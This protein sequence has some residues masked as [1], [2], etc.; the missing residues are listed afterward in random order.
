MRVP[1]IRERLRDQRRSALVGRE[2]ELARLLAALDEDGP[3]LTFVLGLGG[4]GKTSLLEAFVTRLEERAIPVRRLDC[5][6]V[7]PTP[8]GLL[9][10]LGE[11]IGARLETP[12]GAA[13][14]VAELGP[15]LVLAFDHYE[16]FR[17]LDGWLRQEL[18]PA[19]PSTVK[20][21]VFGRTAPVD[22]WTADPGWATLVRT[23]RLGPLDETSSRALLERHGI[24]AESM[25]RLLRFTRGHPLALRLA[26]QTFED[27]PDQALDEAERR[28]AVDVLAPM[29]LR[30]V[31][32]EPVRR[33]LEAGC[34]VRRA[35]RS[36]LAAM[37]PEA[38]QEEAF[39]ALRELPFV[40]AAADGLVVHETVQAAIAT[41]L[42]AL[43]PVRYQSLRSSAW[44]CLRAEL[45]MAPR[46]Q[47]WRYTADMLYLVDR[48]QIREAFF[49]AD[50]DSYGV[51]P[52]RREDW[53]AIRELAR[54]FDDGAAASV[55][56]WWKSMPWAFHV[57]RGV[58]GRPRAFYNFALAQQATKALGD[59][60][61]LV[62]R[63]LAHLR[64]EGVSLD[65]PIFFAPRV[66]AE[67]TG[68]APSPLAIACWLDAK[69]AYLEHPT[70]RRIYTGMAQPEVSLGVLAA[71]GFEAPPELGPGVAGVGVGTLMLDF[72]PGGVLGWLARTVDAQ[73]AD[74]QFAPAGSWLDVNAR[75]LR[76]GSAT[77]P[78]TKL[79]FSVMRYLQER[80]GRVVTRD[81]LLRDVW[82]QSFGGSN[83]VDAVVRTLRKKLGAQGP[84]VETVIGHGYR[85]TGFSG[86]P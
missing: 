38:F 74:A 53:D 57:V 80:S 27:R 79:E 30:D 39:Q 76:L 32:D 66:L 1:R 24:P 64:V 49:P 5:R 71:L 8:A 58:S 18:L 69:R 60:D 37:V 54:A 21:F 48:P 68:E 15:R 31:R 62:R 50:L 17:L 33:L 12:A 51:E 77:V 44:T 52:A 84:A 78:L 35:T 75:A 36:V 22:A 46:N 55:E 47:L 10:T 4:M 40:E 9:G 34:L 59:R 6:A 56:L 3:V 67:G 86:L 63:W 23:L 28:P 7:E 19:L 42:R 43:D 45:G 61:S 73:F 14:R 29:F 25:P 85:F 16:A 13:E 20:V 83:I 72:G 81:E 26:G 70:A 11:L 2:Q 65:R 41:A 82:G